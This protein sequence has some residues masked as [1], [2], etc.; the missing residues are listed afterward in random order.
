M[1]N[2]IRFS[3][4]A[5]DEENKYGR[6]TQNAEKGKKQ[7]HPDVSDATGLRRSPRETSSRRIIS[8]PSSIRRSG[9]FKKG[10]VTRIPVDKKRS[11]LVGKKNMPSPLRR[12]GRTGSYSSTSHSDSKSSGSLNSNPKPKKEKSVRQLTFEA[13]EVKENEEQDLGT[14]QVEV[15]RMNARMYRSFFELPKEGNIPRC[16]VSFLF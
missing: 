11:E 9:Q 4:S 5:K 10:V 3:H 12:S 6:V 16:L 15:R 14:P 1:V 2:S 7:L 8:G 13:K